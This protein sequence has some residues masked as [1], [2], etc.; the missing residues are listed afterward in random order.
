MLYDFETP[1]TNL[2]INPKQDAATKAHYD[3]IMRKF[4]SSRGKEN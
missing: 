3:C 2:R 1:S 4:F